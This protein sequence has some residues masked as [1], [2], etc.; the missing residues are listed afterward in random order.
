M[1]IRFINIRLWL[2]CCLLSAIQCFAQQPGINF[3]EQKGS[4]FYHR[5]EDPK[6]SLSS[7]EITE[8]RNEDGLPVWFGR[9]FRK[10][11]CLTGQCRMVHVWLFWDGAGNYLR[12]QEHPGDLL[13]KTDHTLFGPEDYKKLQF[14]LSDSLSVLKDLK[15]EEL[16]IKPA[17]KQ[18]SVDAVSGATQPY[19]QQYLVKNAA[20]TCYTLWHTVYG[21]T[22]KEIL[23][24]LDQRANEK[25]LKLIFVKNDPVYLRWAVDYIRRNP[26]YHPVFYR[27]IIGLIKTND[28]TLSKQALN[29]FSAN[30][31][32]DFHLQK[33]L[34]ERLNDF[35]YQ[36]KF[37]LLWN[38]A[39]VP[40][41]NDEVILYLLE[42]FEKDQINSTLL[43]YS[44]KLIRK[45]NL[46]N[47][48]IQRKLNSLIAHE[49]LYVRNI[50]KKLLTQ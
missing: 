21:I 1:I 10:V 13:S 38:L 8:L 15:Q 14:I 27:Q 46:N 32:T 18:G 5:I 43:G 30:R 25:H 47:P 39:A 26:Q 17:A 35:G 4:L 41:I 7:H 20:Y 40:K 49:N 50:T 37:E 28:E 24:L 16:I 33:E 12:F 31:L 3:M 44:F 22:R 42:L 48:E 6:D 23:D 19:L 45:D 34:I 29:Y 2:V 11:V 9:D 36:R